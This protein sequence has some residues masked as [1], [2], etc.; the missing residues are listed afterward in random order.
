MLLFRRKNGLHEVSP[1]INAWPLKA[2]QLRTRAPIFSALDT[3][4]AATSKCGFEL[5]DRIFSNEGGGGIFPTA[6]RP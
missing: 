6:S 1:T 5:R 2:A 3:P 4:S